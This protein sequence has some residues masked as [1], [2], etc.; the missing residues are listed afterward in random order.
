MLASSF[1][2]LLGIF[3]GVA[4]LAAVAADSEQV[5]DAKRRLRRIL[6]TE[7]IEIPVADPRPSIGI[8]VGVA[9]AGG[10]LG[11]IAGWQGQEL[12][13]LSERWHSGTLLKDEFSGVGEAA[14]TAAATGSG[15][16][17][18]AVGTGGAG[19]TVLVV[20]AGIAG[21]QAPVVAVV[22]PTP[23]GV[24]FSIGGRW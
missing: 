24:A 20:S 2:V 10:V 12:Q 21:D 8:G 18:A 22:L 23:G 15:L 16:T 13:T 1:L 17:A 14:T 11:A 3:S 5:R 9:A 4:F 6:V 7:A 19:I